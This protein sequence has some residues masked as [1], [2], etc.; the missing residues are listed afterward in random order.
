M[1]QGRSGDLKCMHGACYVTGTHGCGYAAGCSM[2]NVHLELYTIAITMGFEGDAM[3]YQCFEAVLGDAS[4][5]RP[6]VSDGSETGGRG[7]A[8]TTRQ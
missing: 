7:G 5:A 3:L 4:H 1:Y 2:N 6:A 8:V